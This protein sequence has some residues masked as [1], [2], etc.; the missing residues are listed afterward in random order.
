[1]GAKRNIEITGTRKKRTIEDYRNEFL[2]ARKVL[3]S[4]CREIG[5][6]YAHI[7]QEFTA[8]NI[9]ELSIQELDKLKQ[10]IKSIVV[11][12]IKEGCVPSW[13]EVISVTYS[14]DE[15][16][17]VSSNIERTVTMDPL[18]NYEYYSGTIQIL[19]RMRRGNKE[20]E[21]ALDEIRA[22]AEENSFA[23]TLNRFTLLTHSIYKSEV[24]QAEH[25]GFEMQMLKKNSG[26][27]SI[28]D[29]LGY[30]G[31]RRGQE[32]NGDSQPG[33]GE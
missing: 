17:I 26:G 7:F 5:I 11:E 22:F 3:K 31:V 8:K 27:E 15:A 24:I 2:T 20:K 33:S 12:L 19:D 9:E 30:L 13:R 32:A 1:M 23:D 25:D 10:E 14:R 6:N 4:V 28:F 16:E 29:Y 21:K 18:G